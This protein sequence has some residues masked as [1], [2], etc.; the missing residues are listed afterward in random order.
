MHIA[1]ADDPLAQHWLTPAQLARAREAGRLGKARLLYKDRGGELRIILLEPGTEY[2][3]ARNEQANVSIADDPKVSRLHAKLTC[4]AGE[5]VLEDDQ[6][7]RNRTFV[8]GEPVVTARLHDRDVIRVGRTWI[9]FDAPVSAERPDTTVPDEVADMPEFVG[10]D[11]AIAVE[12]CRPFIFPAEN[13]ALP[14][15]PTNVDIGEALCLTNHAIA[16]RLTA[17]FKRCGIDL[18]KD[19]NRRELTRRLIASGVIT[20]RDYEA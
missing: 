2:L 6:W 11:K 17:I 12:L 7:S 15:V 18:G 14:A 19:E 16:H 4:I 20:R 1:G 9:R 10:T 3:I 5:W 8:N 13:G